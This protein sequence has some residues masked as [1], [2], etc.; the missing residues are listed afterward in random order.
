MG[1]KQISVGHMRKAIG[2]NQLV[3]SVG[4]CYNAQKK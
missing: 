2:I 4:Q 1:T 3:F